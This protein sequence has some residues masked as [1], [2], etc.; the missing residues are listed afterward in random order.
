MKVLI[1]NGSLRINGNT[2][3]VINEMA[4]TFHEEDATIDTMP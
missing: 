1:I 2:S 4:K 3:I